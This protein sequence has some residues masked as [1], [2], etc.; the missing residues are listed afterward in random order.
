MPAMMV[1]TSAKSRLMMPGM[2]MM[3]EI[4]C[5]AWRKMS[6]AMRNDSKK[7]ALCAT[8]SNF[9]LGMA[10]IV[11]TLST[12]SASPRSACPRRRRPSKANGL[13]TTA[14]VSAP[15]SLASEAM[16]GAAPVPVPPPRPAVTN[17][18]SAP[19]RASMILSASSSAPRRPISGLAPAPRPLVSLVPSWIFTGA[20]DICN[21]C[22]SVLAAT[23]STPSTP[24]QIIR[25]TA[26]PPPPPTPITLI[27]ALFLGSS[28]KWMRI[29]FSP[30]FFFSSLM[31]SHS[32]TV[33]FPIFFP[34][35]REF[36]LTLSP[37]LRKQRAQ[38]VAES[39]HFRHLGDGGAVR[40]H[41]QADY[42]SELRLRQL[43]R[44][45]RDGCRRSQPHRGLHDFLEH[46]R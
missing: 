45:L 46:L 24:A 4:P 26:L 13:V 3:S 23:N 35:N 29:S 37:E 40:V 19:S 36:P 25:L 30:C 1:F 18:M 9:S 15:I 6:S 21:A 7:P 42:G 22:K 5:T 2:V 14:T 31:R 28:L 38:L 17:T 16:I 8:A 27:L 32:E 11:S 34:V 12:S 43:R 33:V 41:G 20:R 10:I 44:H 39:L